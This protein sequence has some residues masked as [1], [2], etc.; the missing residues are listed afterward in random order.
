MRWMLAAV[1][2]ALLWPAGEVGAANLDATPHLILRPSAIHAGGSVFVS[3]RGFAANRRVAIQVACPS[4][5]AQMSLRLTVAQGP[6][7]NAKGS[8]AGFRVKTPLAGKGRCT[9]YAGEG[10]A[11]VLAAATY[12][13]VPAGEKLPRCS[14]TMCMHVKAFI[15]RLKN[16]T[17]G[18]VVV[19][20]WPGARA[21]IVVSG[22]KIN[23]KVRSIRLNWRG[24]AQKRLRVALGVIKSIKAQVV[25]TARLG[26]VRGTA[27]AKFAVIPG[28]R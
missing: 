28:G 14:K 10:L 19:T 27:R 2:I 18:T 20:G 16:G 11:G 13:V 25:V 22:P 12:R 24:V 5:S 6:A 9:V 3:G 8:F 4:L 26:R 7:V 1:T 21:R 23:T 15:I 17:Q